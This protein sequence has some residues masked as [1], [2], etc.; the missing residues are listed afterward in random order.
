M[1]G[2]VGF[3]QNMVKYSPQAILNDCKYTR[4]L[5]LNEYKNFWLYPDNQDNS[6]IEQH[7]KNQFADQK[8]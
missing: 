4:D 2:V 8:I 5:Y 1:F 7:Q 6:V 3:S